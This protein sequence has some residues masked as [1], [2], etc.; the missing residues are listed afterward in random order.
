MNTTSFAK[1]K[2]SNYWKRW[3]YQG[4][5]LSLSQDL[6]QLRLYFLLVT[7]RTAWHRQIYTEADLGMCSMFGQLGAPQNAPFLHARE[8]RT[9]ARHF[10]A[11]EYIE[12]RAAAMTMLKNNKIK[13][14]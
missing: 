7:P 2:N 9:A 1:D 8:C 4:L 13:L 3:R 6:L 12:P 11:G 10:L 5:L 14:G